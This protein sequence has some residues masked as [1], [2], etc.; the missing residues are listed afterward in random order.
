[1]P[2]NEITI[3]SPKLGS[4]TY[5]EDDLITLSTPLLGFGELSDYLII[6]NSDYFPFLWLQS[7]EDPSVCFILI[8]PEP[9][10]EDYAP[11]VNKRELK[12]LGVGELKDLK[13]FCIVVIPDN[14]QKATAN[15]RAPF[16]VNFERKIAKQI[17]LDDD[18]WSIRAPLF[19]QTAG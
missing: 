7:V 2:E 10:F 5:K 1:M 4:I 8:E 11:N 6:A 15:L 16:A 9:F 18:K 12:V 17:V 13:I 3:H 14:P 19:P